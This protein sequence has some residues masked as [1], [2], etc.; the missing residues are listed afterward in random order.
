MQ[1]AGFIVYSRGTLEIVDRPGLESAACE[2]YAL[3]RDEYR[4]LISA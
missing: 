2:C 1:R 4:R 3:I